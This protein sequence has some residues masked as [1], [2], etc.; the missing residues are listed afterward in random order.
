MKRSHLSSPPSPTSLRAEPELKKAKTSP[1]SFA[2]LATVG[3]DGGW[4]KVEK[5]KAKK[6]KKT[7]GRMDVRLLF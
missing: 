3:D 2:E 6:A 1:N 7:A 4:T 5:R